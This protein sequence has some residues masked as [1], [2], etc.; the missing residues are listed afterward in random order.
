MM[1][2]KTQALVKKLGILHDSMIRAKY[3]DRTKIEA[4]SEAIHI[5]IKMEDEF[6]K[7]Y[8]QGKADEA[9]LRDR[10]LMQTFSPDKD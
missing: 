7:H 4:V 2:P 5:L 1:S 9:A 10:K 8:E 6:M 3:P